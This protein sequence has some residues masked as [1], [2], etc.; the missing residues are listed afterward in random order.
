MI[1]D[2]H[3]DHRL[4]SL[5]TSAVIGSRRSWPLAGLLQLASGHESG[6]RARLQLQIDP[7]TVTLISLILTCTVGTLDWRLV[8]KVA[9]DCFWPLQVFMDVEFVWKHE[10]G[11]QHC[12]QLPAKFFSFVYYIC[13][14]GGGES[15]I[16]ISHSVFL[17][18][19]CHSV[20]QHYYTCL[21]FVVLLHFSID[22]L[23]T[24][25]PFKSF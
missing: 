21:Y 24:S 5:P 1:H 13:R 7:F 3:H 11:L 9:T 22:F 20:F 19:A 25:D 23:E 4:P 8:F 10:L 15:N 2:H 12:Q 17:A 18:F 16:N 14:R 6:A